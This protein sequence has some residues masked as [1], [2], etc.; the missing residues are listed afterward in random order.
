MY[1]DQWLVIR[2]ADRRIVHAA[3]PRAVKECLRWVKTW[4]EDDYMKTR[5]GS[6]LSERCDL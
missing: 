3:G 6:P 2:R 5:K 1:G 4:G